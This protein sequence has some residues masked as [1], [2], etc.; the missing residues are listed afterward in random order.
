ME[1]PAL[2]PMLDR[3]TGQSKLEKLRPSHDAVLRCGETIDPA[4]RR[5]T[6]LAAH[7]RLR[8]SRG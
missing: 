5:S 3:V 2:D 7:G 6:R 1:S 8:S 4:E